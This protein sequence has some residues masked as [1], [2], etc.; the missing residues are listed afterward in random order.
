[1]K[2]VKKIL[3]L[4]IIIMVGIFYSKAVYADLYSADLTLISEENTS[5][6]T[7][8]DIND[9]TTPFEDPKYSFS[10][11]PSSD[12]ILTTWG[13]S[14]SYYV[15]A[16]ANFTNVDT[17]GQLLIG[18]NINV[19]SGNVG[20]L[21]QNCGT[22]QGKKIAIKGTY[23]WDDTLSP[24]MGILIDETHHA[25]YADF[26]ENYPYSIK[27]E[28][29]Q[30]DSLN[31]NNGNE[32]TGTSFPVNMTT[33]FG[34]I[35]YYQRFKVQFNNGNV[36]KIKVLKTTDYKMGINK[37]NDNTYEIGDKIGT[38]ESDI[39]EESIMFL[40]SEID[41]FTVTYGM[42]NTDRTNTYL[43]DSINAVLGTSGTHEIATGQW[44]S[45]G[46]YGFMP[47][48]T[49]TPIKTIIN[50]E[51]ALVNNN[52]V[53]RIGETFKY[54]IIA[55]VPGE[56]NPDYYYSKYEIIDEIPQ[57]VTVNTDDITIIDNVED[58]V[59]TKFNITKTGNTIT[60]SKKDTTN[61]ADMYPNEYRIIISAQINS[62]QYNGIYKNT[63]IISTD[64]GNKESNEVSTTLIQD[65]TKT[66]NDDQSKK[67]DIG[68]AFTFKI[69][70]EVPN[71]SNQF[72]NFTFIDTLESVL[73]VNSSNI[74]IVNEN[75]VDVTSKFNIAVSSQ[76]I[77]ATLINPNDND[78]YGHTYTMEIDSSIKENTDLTA[79]QISEF[80]YIIT[81]KA[82]VKINNE[83]KTTNEVDVIYEPNVPDSPIKSVKTTSTLGTV[84]IKEEFTYEVKQI[85]P[86]L[87]AYYTSFK[88]E[89]TLENALYVNQSNISITNEENTNVT[90]KFNITVSGQ[91]ITASLIDLNDTSF[92]NHTYTLKIKTYIKENYELTAYKVSDDSYIIPNTATVTINDTT[93]DSNEVTVIYEPDNP[94]AP[95]KV[96]DKMKV[97]IKEEFT[98]KITQT[99]PTL[100]SYYTNFNII[101]ELEDALYVSKDNISITN[102]NDNDVTSNFNINIDDQKITITSNNLNDTSFY[103][104][105]YNV[106]IKTYIKENYELSAYQTS[107]NLY[108][109]PNKATVTINNDS[110]ETNEVIITHEVTSPE[111]PTKT[112]SDYTV[113]LNENF[114]YEIIQK[115][116]ILSS[117]YNS[118][119]IEDTLEN[120]LE[121]NS[122]NIK[123][124][125]EDDNDVT[126]KFQVSING[127]TVKAELKN[128]KD[129][130]FYGHT[131]K[132]LIDTN[133]KENADYS[134]YKT[135]DGYTIP[136]TAT[137]TI[138]NNKNS[139]NEVVV[140]LKKYLVT[141]EVING[142]IDSSKDVLEGGN[143]T[144][145]YSPNKG[146]YL[147]EIYIDD[148]R[149][150]INEY[151]DSY[152]FINISQDHHIKVVYN[153]IE[154][155]N[156]K[157]GI[158]N[159]LS[160]SLIIIAGGF[161]LYK[162][163][164][165]NELFQ[166]L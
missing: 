70:Q 31:L 94:T 40:V 14:S 79:Y 54:Q 26:N 44:V 71:V 165:K 87:S 39:P 11:Y 103:G 2:K 95:L 111:N 10:F 37:I 99:I 32:P 143:I 120:I 69:T 91:K 147:D 24:A 153:K 140:L 21:L 121:T 7:F 19:T 135:D 5:Y 148:I 117:F 34:D 72:S 51:N 36:D 15:N 50:S 142:N 16:Y 35:D 61:D 56:I 129:Y 55:S 84:G 125:D 43:I 163:L 28:I 109:I 12:T 57:G 82:T 88:F 9:S 133:L 90:D 155:D 100:S 137:V 75:N 76:T 86:K 49:P 115:V 151:E 113:K 105:T 92:Y 33:M 160:I 25:V 161:G 89:D 104:H 38:I 138:N 29:L 85:I 166:K 93:R 62:I 102:E 45:F 60:I 96:A 97:E 141:T 122:N 146:Y 27:Y 136:N 108:I 130:N 106:L 73:V 74:K 83:S 119:I 23:Y 124:L 81:N 107:D 8:V 13:I 77:N 53:F 58:D 22:Y 65:P 101:D 46:G 47:Y 131:Y 67:V 126:S 52:E 110:N 98:Y 42:I 158:N 41:D 116:P 63:A 128:L 112:V 68:E 127:Q 3:K 20:F 157:T 145:N 80:Q 144:I 154:V 132:L 149:Q 123:V 164:K 156:P 162:Y 159:F 48:D 30:Q 4:F 17:T 1:M 139:T 134:N 152:S 66:I 64:R 150:N 18:D 114:T 6:L 118:F 59:T 78:F